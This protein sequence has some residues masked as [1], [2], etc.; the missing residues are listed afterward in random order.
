MNTNT[1]YG[2]AVTGALGNLGWKLL[3]HLAQYGETST[4]IGLDLQATTP[5]KLEHLKT[6]SQNNPR[7]NEIDLIECDLANWDDSRWRDVI[8]RV[9][10]VV[11]LAAQNPYPDAT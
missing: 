7:L 9:S 3:C 2:I 5:E 8:N 11:H 1:Q 6:I 4:L 10:T